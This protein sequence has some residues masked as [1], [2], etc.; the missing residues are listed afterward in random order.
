MAALIS[1]LAL[2][3]H[4]AVPRMTR[5]TEFRVDVLELRCCRFL[6]TPSK[7]FFGTGSKS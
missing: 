3:R 2:R 6:K 7:V 1:N 5:A 4:A